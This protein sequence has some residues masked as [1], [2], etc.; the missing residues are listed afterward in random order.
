MKPPYTRFFW[1]DWIADTSHLDLMQR[2]A[3]MA[4]LEYVY[5]H[6]RPLPGDF[7]RIYR[8]CHAITPTEQNS[9][10]HVLGEYFKPFE[11]PEHG[12]VFRH[13]RAEREIEWSDRQ[14]QEA[15]IQGAIGAWMRWG[16]EESRMVLENLGIP[17]PD[18]GPN[19]GAK[20]GNLNSENRGAISNQ[21]QNQNHNQ[22]K[23]KTRAS[24]A[25]SAT[26]EIPPKD[27]DPETWAGFVEVRISRKAAQTDRAYTMLVNE[28][29]NIA[30]ITGEPK[31]EIIARSVVNSWKSVFAR[32]NGT[33]LHDSV[34]APDCH[35]DHRR[36]IRD[37]VDAAMATARKRP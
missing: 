2:G 32:N 5:Q 34:A 16:S 14:H 35:P 18:R 28:L 26:W 3:Y 9:I 6:R 27:V 1:S 29:E 21:N 4:L 23:R 7:D 22:E 36:N 8:I 10:R 33:K 12:Q 17:V 25:S 37:I 20:N 31:N 15:V 13:L 19:R 30:K 24:K 11:D